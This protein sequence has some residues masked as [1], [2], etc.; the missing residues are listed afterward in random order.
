MSNCG[1]EKR[2]KAGSRKQLMFNQYANTVKQIQSYD[3]KVG[4]KV[5]SMRLGVTEAV[6]LVRRRHLKLQA[7]PNQLYFEPLAAFCV[8]QAQRFGRKSSSTY[9]A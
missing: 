6:F 7:V 8:R 9:L 2:L 3:L 1:K 5:V 4:E